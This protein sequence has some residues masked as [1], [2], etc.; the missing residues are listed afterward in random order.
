M[1]KA[2]KANSTS[3]W[4]EVDRAG[5]AKLRESA[6]KSALVFEL[7]SNVWDTSATKCDVSL[8]RV[9]GTQHFEL[10]VSDDDPNGFGDL[11]H[12]YTI[13]AE[14]S[15][16][17]EA[18][19]RGR[20]NLG[21]KLALALCRTASIASTSGTVIFDED[22]R[23]SS[24]VKRERGSE[25]SG[26]IRMTQ[27]EA[28][29]VAASIRLL[30]VPPDCELTFCK[31]VIPM[32]QPPRKPLSKLEATLPSV[33]SDA[34]G[35]LRPTRRKGVVE[36]HK[37]HDGENPMIYEMGIPVVES[38]DRWHYNV[39]QK[40]PL[41]VDRTNVTPAFLRE[42]RR[43]VAEGMRDF[44]EAEDVHCEWIRAAAAHPE[45]SAE[46]VRKV[47]VERFGEKSA[48]YD[49]S[50]PEANLLA[51]ANGYALVTGSQLSKEE[52]AN[53]REHGTAAPAGRMYPKVPEREE[54][55][56]CT[57]PMCGG[58]GTVNA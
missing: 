35:N 43:C 19:K 29:E 31:D 14:S 13:F 11:T 33:I 25:F 58:R 46:L 2:P 41:T 8:K 48:I 23:R 57:C 21:E 27:V 45:A 53:V 7:I 52:W 3:S 26:I 24:K 18:E 4:F 28:D 6:P 20:F 34:D 9:P 22:G 12:S 42:V 49:P 50:N 30:I 55:P 32:V 15:R 44:I 36:V 17:G 5:L 16:K 51:V 38:G 54:L 1:T 47:W 56:K 10:V 37:P 40:V 39:M